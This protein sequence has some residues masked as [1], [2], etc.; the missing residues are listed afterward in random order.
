[1]ADIRERVE[2]IAENILALSEQTQQIGVIIETVGDI[3]AQSARVLQLLE[4]D[5]LHAQMA[6]A[7]RTSAVERFASTA[8][9]PQYEQYYQHVMQLPV[10][11]GHQQ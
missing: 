8:I 5:A 1:M 2:S 7:A 6:H 4:D 3:A 9:I 11:A 10:V